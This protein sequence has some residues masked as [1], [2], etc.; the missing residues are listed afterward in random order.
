MEIPRGKLEE[1]PRLT[2]WGE[3][4]LDHALESE[5]GKKTPEEI[6]PE[7]EEKKEEKTKDYQLDR[8]LDLVQAIWIAN[9]REE[10]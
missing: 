2:G 3:E 8:A 6:L 10:K 1:Y 7:K 5:D 9:Q 4:N